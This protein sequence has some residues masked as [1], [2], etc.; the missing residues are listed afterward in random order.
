MKI[1]CR[2]VMLEILDLKMQKL[3]AIIIYD[4][5]NFLSI[6]FIFNKKK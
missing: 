3:V 5:T 2:P 4:P 6:I 1:V